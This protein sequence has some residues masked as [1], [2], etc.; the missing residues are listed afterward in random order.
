[1]QAGLAAKENGP[2]GPGQIFPPVGLFVKFLT[3]YYF[4]SF[5]YLSICR[6]SIFQGKKVRRPKN[7]CYTF[8][9]RL[10]AHSVTR[11]VIAILQTRNSAAESSRISVVTSVCVW[12]SQEKELLVATLASLICSDQLRRCRTTARRDSCARLLGRSRSTCYC[13]L[14]GKPSPSSLVFKSCPNFFE[15]SLSSASTRSQ[16]CG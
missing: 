2:G 3:F 5:E 15:Q 13:K 16:N 12:P 4:F 14:Y 1:M 9:N 11:T 6:V 10:Q 7:S 8:Y